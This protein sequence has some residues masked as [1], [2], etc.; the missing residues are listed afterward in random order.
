MID[1]KYFRNQRKGLHCRSKK[2]KIDILVIVRASLKHLLQ[3][4]ASPVGLRR[5]NMI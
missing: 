1:E 4:E 3:R 2:C 5:E